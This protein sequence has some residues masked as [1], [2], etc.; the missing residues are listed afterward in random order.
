MDVASKVVSSIPTSECSPSST[1]SFPS[2]ATKARIFPHGWTMK[3]TKMFGRRCR[4]L[5]FRL[6]F[7]RIGIADGAAAGV[8]RWKVHEATRLIFQNGRKSTAIDAI[9]FGHWRMERPRS[10][11]GRSLNN[12]HNF[13]ICFDGSNGFGKQSLCF[14]WLISASSWATEVIS[15]EEESATALRDRKR[16]DMPRVMLRYAGWTMLHKKGVV[17]SWFS[18]GYDPLSGMSNLR[19]FQVAKKVLCG[20]RRS[21]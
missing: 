19:F 10:T 18:S 16:S 4:N 9:Y 2:T 8:E 17:S 15:I 11:D 14:G 20:A 6:W 7:R 3:E 1:T 5:H 13:R 12:N 21:Q